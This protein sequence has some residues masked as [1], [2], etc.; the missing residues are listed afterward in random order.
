MTALIYEVTPTDLTTFAVAVATVVGTAVAACCG[1]AV[2]ASLTDPLVAL[3][4]D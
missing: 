3:R 2:K 4:C 1:P